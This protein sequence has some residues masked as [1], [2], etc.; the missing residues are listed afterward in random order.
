MVLVGIGSGMST[1]HAMGTRVNGT[2]SDDTLA[3]VDII[4][5]KMYIP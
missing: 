3:D 1:G 2:C 4:A 5:R